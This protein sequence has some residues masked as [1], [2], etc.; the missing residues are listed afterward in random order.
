MHELSI[1]KSSTSKIRVEF[2]GI[3]GGLPAGP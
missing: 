3:C 1:E 2:G